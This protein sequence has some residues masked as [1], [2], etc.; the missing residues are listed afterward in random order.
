MCYVTVTL[1]YG[2]QQ[3]DLAH[4]LSDTGS[5]GTLFAADQVLAIGLQYEA[6]DPVQCI[7]RIGGAS[8]V[9]PGQRH[10]DDDHEESDNGQGPRHRSAVR[11]Q[12]EMSIR[13]PGFCG[14]REHGSSNGDGQ[15]EA[16]RRPPDLTQKCPG[17]RDD[18]AR[19]PDV[20]GQMH[21]AKMAYHCAHGRW[22]DSGVQQS[23]PDGVKDIAES[24]QDERDPDPPSS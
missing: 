24:L 14:G 13:V 4:V 9:P 16:R 2:D 1:L 12:A 6:D 8:P 21:R 23:M 18:H 7:R 15:R 10:R 22:L 20:E 5:A 17:C 11:V 19:G 3:L